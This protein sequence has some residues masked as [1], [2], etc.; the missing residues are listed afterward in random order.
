MK[1]GGEREGE[2][3]GAI[4]SHPGRWLTEGQGES[5]RGPQSA[6]GDRPK[7][8]VPRG[9]SVSSSVG[10]FESYSSPGEGLTCGAPSWLAGAFSPFLCQAQALGQGLYPPAAIGVFMLHG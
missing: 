7:G 10:I 2:D 5:D 4:T 9:D 1:V 6:V 3:G 8:R